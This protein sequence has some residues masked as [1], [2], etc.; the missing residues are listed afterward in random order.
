MEVNSVGAAFYGILPDRH[1]LHVPKIDRR[2]AAAAI[3]DISSG[4]M[5][6]LSPACKTFPL[7]KGPHGQSKEVPT[8]IN[9]T[10]T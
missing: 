10:S 7:D 5:K 8:A 3:D 6:K 1:V 9:L 4:G 2:K